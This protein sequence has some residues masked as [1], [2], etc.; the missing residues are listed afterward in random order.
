MSLEKLIVDGRIHPARIEEMVENGGGE[1]KVEECC[2]FVFF[3][4]KTS[5]SFGVVDGLGPSSKVRAMVFD[6]FIVS[7]V[8]LK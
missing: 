5:K 2:L 4:F 8:S 6:D 3:C 1:L 7:S